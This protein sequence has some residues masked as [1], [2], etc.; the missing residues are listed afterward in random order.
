M[1]IKEEILVS[2][3]ILTFNSASTV[4]ETLESI[5]KQT[6]KNIELIVSDDCSKDNTVDLCHEWISNNATR[7]AR[8]EL[9]T[10][11]KNTGVSSNA[12]RALAACKGEWMKCI[13]GDDIMFPNCVED[14]VRFIKQHPDAKWVSSYVSEYCGTFDEPNCRGHNMVYSRSFFDFPADKQLWVIVR[15]NLIY[16]PSVFYNVGALGEVGGFDTQYRIEDFPMYIKLLVHGY[17]CYFLD[18]ETIGYRIH[19]SLAHSDQHLL[20][21]HG[22]LNSRKVRREISLKFL[23]KKEILGLKCLWEVEDLIEKCGMNSKKNIL[24]YVF[25]RVARFL[26]YR[27]FVTDVKNLL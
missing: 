17:K 11:S 25:Y 3:P 22:L 9:I 21:Y 27:V 6:Y 2:C 7:F 8:I 13:A 24:S 18:K 4:I 20:N 23:D 16:A 19:D 12:N 26:V 10:V 1:E 5:K 14:L 15:R